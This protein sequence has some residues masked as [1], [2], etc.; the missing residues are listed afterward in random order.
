MSLT[1]SNLTRNAGA[2]RKPKRIGRG[3]GSGHGKT[4]TRGHKG[5]KSRSGYKSRAGFEGGQMPLYRRLPKRGFHNPF[6]KHYNEINLAR[7]DMFEAGAVVTPEVLLERRIIRKKKDGV[8]VLG[9]GDLTKAL[10][11]HA[12]HF[13]RGAAEKIEKAGGKIEVLL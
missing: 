9:N 6:R 1:L 10:V 8:R 5:Q 7:L 11:I 12:H 2:N 3:P 4:A 13:T